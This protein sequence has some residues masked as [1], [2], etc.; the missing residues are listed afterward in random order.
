ML[1]PFPFELCAHF[2]A[3]AQLAV[4]SAAGW[5][6]APGV[7]RVAE[8]PHERDASLR[9]VTVTGELQSGD[10]D[11]A[12]AAMLA[13]TRGIAS[14]WQLQAPLARS[15]GR[16][17]LNAEA[18]TRVDGARMAWFELAGPIAPVSA[19]PTTEHQVLTLELRMGVKTIDK[20]R[21]VIARL[22]PERA[23]SLSAGRQIGA[24]EA[25]VVVSVER[26]PTRGAG[27]ADVLDILGPIA[28]RWQVSQ[29]TMGFGLAAVVRTI[30]PSGVVACTTTYPPASR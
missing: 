8:A 1:Q 25:A 15:S 21:A 17:H 2:D 23:W 24:R 6:V 14:S 22:W 20:A 5:R 4:T 13:L 3:A 30:R 9:V 29:Q 19:Q 11:R 27:W 28:S 16:F 26:R 10:L 18:A 7:V 12:I